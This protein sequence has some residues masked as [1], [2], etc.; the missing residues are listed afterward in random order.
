MS[1]ACEPTYVDKLIAAL[2]HADLEFQ[3]RHSVASVTRGGARLDQARAD[4]VAEGPRRDL[5]GPSEAVC[6]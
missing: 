5:R 4:V 2:S 3:R 1:E 6:I